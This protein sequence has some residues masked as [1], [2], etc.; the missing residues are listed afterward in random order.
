[1]NE[2]TELPWTPSGRLL[3][4]LII[5]E[6]EKNGKYVYGREN[7]ASIEFEKYTRVVYDNSYALASIHD[8]DP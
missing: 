2:H 8:S 7:L 1:M 3:L 4:Q 6:V 5:R